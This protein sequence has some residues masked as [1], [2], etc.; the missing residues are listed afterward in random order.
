MG[1]PL[2]AAGTSFRIKAQ[3]EKTDFMEGARCLE[4]EKTEERRPRD[5]EEEFPASTQTPENNET[6][7]AGTQETTIPG[8]RHDPGG[9][10]LYKYSDRRW[11]AKHDIV[12]AKKE[13]LKIFE[14]ANAE[15]SRVGSIPRIH[16]LFTPSGSMPQVKGL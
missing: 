4:P 3:K 12:V 15:D 6:A 9:S 10:W 1:T 5:A 7:S 2:D 16:E 13:Q 14:E 8:A 11:W